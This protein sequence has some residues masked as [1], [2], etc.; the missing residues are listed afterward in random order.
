M[1]LHVLAALLFAAAVVL[2]PFGARSTFAEGPDDATIAAAAPVLA[3]FSPATISLSTD[4]DIANPSRGVQAY[5]GGDTPFV[6]SNWSYTDSYSRDNLYWYELEPSEGVYNFSQIDEYLKEAAAHGGK[7][8]F[9]IS[10]ADAA[11]RTHKAPFVPKYLWDRMPGAYTYV[12][13]GATIYMPDFDDPAFI[14]RAK[15]LIAALAARYADDPRLGWIEAGFMG[16]W[17]EWHVLNA[18]KITRGTLAHQAWTV[19]NG[20]QIVDAWH[21]SFPNTRLIVMTLDF[22]VL[23]Y[24]LGLDPRIGWRHDCLGSQSL[25]S[26]QQNPGYLNH[27]DQWKTAPIYWEACGPNTSVQLAHDQVLR[28]HF[29]GGHTIGG[30][31]QSRVSPADQNLLKEYRK[32]SGYRI[33]VDNV[34][35]PVRVVPGS[36]FA[37]EVD[38]SNLG[39]TPAYNQWSLQIQLREQSGGKVAWQGTSGLDLQTLLPTRDLASGNDSPNQFSDTFTLP[40]DIAAGTYDVVVLATDPT[41]YYKPL[42]LANQGRRDDGSYLLGQTTVAP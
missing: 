40:A 22:D 6:D 4:Q 7:Y 37:L 11:T 5:L 8:G 35:M 19:D 14:A 1:R 17:G 36:A 21:T 33:Q 25:D 24:A 27:Q 2:A 10:A 23:D 38:W 41:G 39:L 20:K 18:P 32:L 9:R 31:L 3:T 34:V 16:L 42:A 12:N 15:A 30:P 28:Y 13:D 26:L 29:A